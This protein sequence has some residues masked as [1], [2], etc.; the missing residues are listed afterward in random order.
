M[1]VHEFHY[2]TMAWLD[3]I[4]GSK[5]TELNSAI[6]VYL[7]MED[8]EACSGIQTAINEYIYYLNIK[9]KLLK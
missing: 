8:Y 2:Y 6:R 7:S 5:I 3:L 9:S 4:E 1:T